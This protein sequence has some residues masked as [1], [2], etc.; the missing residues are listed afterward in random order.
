M[1]TSAQYYVPKYLS[2]VKLQA[3]E[4]AHAAGHGKKYIKVLEELT[5]VEVRAEI[6]NET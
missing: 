1:T 2:S 6:E 5:G 3:Y 4:A